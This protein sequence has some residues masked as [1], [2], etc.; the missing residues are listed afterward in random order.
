[1]KKIFSSLLFSSA[2]LGGVVGLSAQ[3]NHVKEKTELLTK[4]SVQATETTRVLLSTP[5][6]VGEPV[7]ESEA[8]SEKNKLVTTLLPTA[9]KVSGSTVEAV[10]YEDIQTVRTG[11]HPVSPEVVKPETLKSAPIPP[12]QPNDAVPAVEKN[13]TLS[14][15]P[16]SLSTNKQSVPEEAASTASPVLRSEAS[17]PVVAASEEKLESAPSSSKETSVE[18]VPVIPPVVT[19]AV[20]AVEVTEVSKPVERPTLAASVD[21]LPTVEEE[22]VL[23]PS[24]SAP[25]SPVVSEVPAFQPTVSK[26]EVFLA[27]SHASVDNTYPIGQCTWGVKTLAPWVGNYWGNAGQ[28]AESARQAGFSVGTTP[29]VGSVA[30]WPNDGGGYGHVA[31]VTAVDSSTRIQVSEANY[32]GN[33]SISN[34]RGWFNPT[35][36][37]WGGGTVYYIYPNYASA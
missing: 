14:L 3:T 32:A 26:A 25:A 31:V 13:P 23:T 36:S 4:P 15:S 17:A 27:S 35:H 33:Q 10:A 29:T 9:N 1:M 8:E 20:P 16:A 18:A 11:F 5:S 21:S 19:E 24:T 2:T 34:Y 7:A 22:V 28:W 12:A 30:V 6:N 37:V